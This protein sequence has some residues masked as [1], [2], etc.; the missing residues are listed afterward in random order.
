M[1]LQFT[2]NGL[3]PKK[4]GAQ[5][6]WG[7]SL[8][9]SCLAELRLVAREALQGSRPFQSNI[10]LTLKI[11][12]GR[13]NDRTIGDLNT[14]VTGVCDGLM[15][16]HPSGKLDPIWND[17]KLKEVHPSRTSAIIDDSQIVQIHAE[18]IIGDTF[19]PWY[20]I[21]LEGEQ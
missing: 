9:A 8:E 14:F 10:K 1:K 15:A 6:M 19:D 16:A 18:K 13:V 4:D 11:H 2:V 20:E 21:T 7:K 3:P 12:I 17:P 5:S